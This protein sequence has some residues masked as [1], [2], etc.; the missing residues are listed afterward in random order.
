MELHSHE[1]EAKQVFYK[2][3]NALVLY[4][5]K[6]QSIGHPLTLTQLRLKI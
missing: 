2:Q 1:K 5:K 3:K 6:M 4:V